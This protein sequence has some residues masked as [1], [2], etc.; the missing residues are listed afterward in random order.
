MNDQKALFYLI[1]KRLIYYHITTYKGDSMPP[2]STPQDKNKKGF[3]VYAPR[4][5]VDAFDMAVSLGYFDAKSRN[6]AIVKLMKSALKDLFFVIEAFDTARKKVESEKYKKS[7]LPKE[8]LHLQLAMEL[9]TDTPSSESIME[10]YQA[11]IGTTMA[12]SKNPKFEDLKNKLNLLF[13]KQNGEKDE[14]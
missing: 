8:V 1:T 14:S 4:E 3:L 10:R 13:N 7:S 2:E 12:N 11:I 5:V 9:I 6:E